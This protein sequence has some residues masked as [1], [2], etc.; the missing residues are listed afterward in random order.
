[1]NSPQA[2]NPSRASSM[3]GASTWAG[4]SR[5]NRSWASAQDRTA[6][7]T[8]IVSGPRRG[9]VVTPRSRSVAASI[10]RA[11]RPDPLSATWRDS[12]ASQISQNASPPM[13]Q[14]FGTTTPSTA[15]VAIAAST[16]DPPVRRMWRPAAVAR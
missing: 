4:V 15:F 10:P 9:I 14:W 1:M 2:G 16:A 6:P 5:P 3:A 8:V 7:G 12:A 13:P 11:L